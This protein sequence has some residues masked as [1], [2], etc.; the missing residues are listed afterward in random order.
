MSAKKIIPL[1]TLER[2]RELFTLDETLG[3]LIARTNRPKC[4][5]GTVIGTRNCWGRLVCRVDYRIYYVHRLIWK[6]K[7]GRDPDNLVD[8]ADRTTDNN[9]ASNLRDATHAQ[10]GWNRRVNKS[11]KSG[12]KGAH[13]SSR[14]KRWKSAIKRG[15]KNIHL[16]WFDS[17]EE[18]HAAY[19]RASLSRDG[20]FSSFSGTIIVR[21]MG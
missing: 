6:M 1:P 5:H 13:W 8:H 16:G 10:N 12:L 9:V 3:V 20:E 2:L 7:N 18:A 19:I 17:K 4:P 21:S 14:E 11:T 15:G